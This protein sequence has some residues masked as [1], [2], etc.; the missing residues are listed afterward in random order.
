MKKFVLTVLVMV[1]SITSVLAKNVKVEAMSEFSTLNPPSEWQVKIAESFTTKSGE[2]IYEGSII[3]G[4]IEEIQDPKRL[5]R[6]AN[7][8][9]IPT[10]YY[11]AITEITYPVNQYIVGKYNSLGDRKSVV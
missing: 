7:F 8:K 9:F 1:L 11:D 6:N 5:K 3:T 2:T 4:K 10:S